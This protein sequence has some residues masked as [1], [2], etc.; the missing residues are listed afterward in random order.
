MHHYRYLVTLILQASRR[1]ATLQLLPS[2]VITELKTQLD[3]V[4]GDDCENQTRRA[5]A[6]LQY[7]VI[8]FGLLRSV[9]TASKE[10]NG[11]LELLCMAASYGNQMAQCIV[12][13]LHETFDESSPFNTNVE[14][15]WL[16]NGTIHG[17]MTARK[18]LMS[19]CPQEYDKAMYRLRHEY[20]GVGLDAEFKENELNAACETAVNT[21]IL[22]RLANVGKAEPFQRI[23][24]LGCHDVNDIDAW[25]ETALL[26]ACRSGHSRIA[27][28][29]LNEGADASIASK[30]GLTPL[31]FLGA[32][33]DNDIPEIATRLLENKAKLEARSTDGKIH[34][35]MLDSQFGKVEGTPLLWAISSGSLTAASILVE[36]GADPFDV[37]GEKMPVTTSWGNYV[38]L[39]PI[40]YAARMHQHDFLEV[41][42]KH[43]QSQSATIC[44]SKLNNGFRLV[45]PQ[46]NFA[47]LPLFWA[48]DYIS[49]SLLERLLLHGNKHQSACRRTI[50]ILVD[51][52]SDPSEL[53]N[54]TR[55]ALDIASLQGHP[56]LTAYILQ[57]HTNLSKVTPSQ[58]LE[59]LFN[60]ARVHDYTSFDLLVEHIKG[61]DMNDD[62]VD[63]FFARTTEITDDIP[64]IDFYLN[65]QRR[66][67]RT[68]LDDNEVF[69]R[70]ILQGNFSTAQRIFED[71][72][73]N[74]RK[75]MVNEWGNESTIFGRLLARSKKYYNAVDKIRFFLSLT[76]GGD[77]AFFDV[78]RL[79]DM[80]MSA[81]HVVSI[82]ADYRP[83]LVSSLPSMNAILEYYYEDR[84]LNDCVSGG[85]YAGCTALHLAI[86]GGNVDSAGRLLNEGAKTD[87][88][89]DQGES[90]FDLVKIRWRNQARYMTDLP[91]D[92]WRAAREDHDRITERLT[93]LLERHDAKARK[94]DGMVKKINPILIELEVFGH[95][96]PDEVLLN[97]ASM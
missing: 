95:A 60:T 27:R 44:S 10:V 16:V 80:E 25:G 43:S 97:S 69:E 15:P 75:R 81:L 1:F 31:H 70:A 84:H 40:D 48:I 74:L 54:R 96:G 73:V 28:M 12:G 61:I 30:E 86:E 47:V 59:L 77:D 21:C 64:F 53:D 57:S 91:H 79:H 13:S 92:R 87:V 23:L 82:H 62:L 14:V 89:N 46:P 55:S 36:L 29:L 72:H 51:H 5:K 4:A 83:D 66:D 76:Q 18:R 7:A 68:N 42:L 67:S 88:V 85:R 19:L 50:Q 35:F 24:G 20:A 17:S 52:G 93:D 9:D 11:A 90:A 2:T 71:G 49:E 8:T 34:Y 33:E 22:H 3:L 6:A 94:Y 39:S 58:F 37:E 65:S 41:L 32:L 63:H 56:F 45:A 38:H 78:G 26:V